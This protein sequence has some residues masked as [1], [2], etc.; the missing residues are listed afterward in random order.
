M[1]AMAME[2]SQ[3]GGRFRDRV[4][5]RVGWTWTYEAQAQGL[6]KSSLRTTSTTY[7]QIPVG[8]GGPPGLPTIQCG[9]A[10]CWVHV[11]V[12]FILTA[13]SRPAKKEPLPVF[14]KQ[15]KSNCWQL[16]GAC[17]MSFDD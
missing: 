13:S 8:G 6:V 1:Q 3:L 16:E 12:V 4:G 9:V 11:H 5:E 15:A 14:R 17:L 7:S 10:A 2:C